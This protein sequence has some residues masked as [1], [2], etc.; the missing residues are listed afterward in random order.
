MRG[1]VMKRIFCLIAILLPLWSVAQVG[2]IWTK[3]YDGRCEA[4]AMMADGGFLIAGEIKHPQYFGNQ[5]LL[6]R[7]DSNGDTLW[8]RTFGTV[9]EVDCSEVSDDY[10]GVTGRMTVSSAEIVRRAFANPDGSFVTL[11]DCYSENAERC[12]CLTTW[13]DVGASARRV[14]FCAT[15]TNVIF[16]LNRTSN[17]QFVVLG[18]PDPYGTYGNRFFVMCVSLSGDTLNYWP[19]ET[20]SDLHLHQ[21]IKPCHDG[22]YVLAGSSPKSVVTRIDPQGNMLWTYQMEKSGGSIGDIAEAADDG[23]IVIGH[24]S[25]ETVR[26]AAAVATKLDAEGALLWQ[27]SYGWD[28]EYRSRTLDVLD[29]GSLLIAGS[30]N[31]YEYARMF[32]MC[33]TGSGDSLWTA[34]VGRGELRAFIKTP[35]GGYLLVG[36]YAGAR[37]FPQQKIVL[38]RTTP[39]E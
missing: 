17:G 36:S 4:V 12:K 25:R 28:S 16:D 39:P 14:P 38:A 35:D 30:F 1:N 10:Y 22:G 15:G 11:T 32:V 7:L 34:D 20:T 37:S 13:N 33:T 26:K 19:Y 29:N 3:E 24:M 23:F 18:S 27:R 9:A 21:M 2:T 6:M 8:T 5:N 31:R